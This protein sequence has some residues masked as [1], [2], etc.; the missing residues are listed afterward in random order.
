LIFVFFLYIYHITLHSIYRQQKQGI[1]TYSSQQLRLWNEVATVFLVAIVILATVKQAV[2]LAWGIGGLL[3]L[4]ILLMTAIR[5]YKKL[6][7]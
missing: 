3:I 5:I 1:F 4:I 6:R 2:S 7:G